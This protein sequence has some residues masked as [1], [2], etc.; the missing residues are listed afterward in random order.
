MDCLS[1]LHGIGGLAII[2]YAAVFLQAAV[3]HETGA[4]ET[5]TFAGRRIPLEEA[6]L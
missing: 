5:Q 3:V 6:G 1:E 2:G 4:S